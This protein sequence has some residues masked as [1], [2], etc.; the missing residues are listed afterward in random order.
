MAHTVVTATVHV[1]TVQMAK[2]VTPA[3]ETVQDNVQ[4]DLKTNC[5]NKNAILVPMESTASNNADIVWMSMDVTSE[6]GVARMA[7]M[8]GSGE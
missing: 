3:P 2:L 5:V 1:G 6:A 8:L 7:A 4:P